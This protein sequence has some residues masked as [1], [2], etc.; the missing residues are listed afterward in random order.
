METVSRLFV[1]KNIF[2]SLVKCIFL[3]T[4]GITRTLVVHPLVAP[5]LRGVRC[6]LF[7]ALA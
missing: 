3:S 7:G 5:R 2:L 6:R 1:K 4:L